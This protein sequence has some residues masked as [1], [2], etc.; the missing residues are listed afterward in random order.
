MADSG[1]KAIETHY[2]GYRFRS[3]LE[4][5][6]AVFFDVIGVS[7]EY[8]KE[9]FDFWGER[10]LP[11]FWL[12]ELNVWFEIKPTEP[13]KDQFGKIARV[14]RSTKSAVV[15]AWGL[16][17]SPSCE[18]REF[19]TESNVS[20]LAPVYSSSGMKCLCGVRQDDGKEAGV[21]LFN[22]FWAMS[23]DLRPVIC[24]GGSIRKLK[25]GGI[26]SSET[27]VGFLSSSEIAGPFTAD[28]YNTAKRA[29]FEFGE[30]GI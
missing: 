20:V 16:P 15:I 13:T 19:A 3:R 17:Q 9:G 29:R 10:Y 4:A 21:F 27:P 22:A 7:Y 6:W 11:D 1:V 28:V 26:F 2:N 5:R 8:E 14:G 24:D 18:I 23:A 30:S 25:L 12:P